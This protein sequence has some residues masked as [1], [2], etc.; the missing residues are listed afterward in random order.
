MPGSAR[1]V[2]STLATSARSTSGARPARDGLRPGPMPPWP[3]AQHGAV[4]ARG[5]FWRSARPSALRNAS[6]VAACVPAAGG[7][8]AAAQVGAPPGGV[9]R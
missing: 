6:P 8:A 2:A 7:S 1:A 4:R 5:G 3:A 9:S